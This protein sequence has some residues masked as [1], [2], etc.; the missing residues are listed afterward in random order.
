MKAESWIEHNLAP[1]RTQHR[2]RQDR[3]WPQAGARLERDGRTLINFAGNDYLGLAGDP[4]LARA[5][6]DAALAL[7]TGATASRLVCGTLDLHRD[8]E[9][10][11]AVFKGYPAALLFGSGYLACAGVLQAAADRGCVI[12]LDRLAHAS[13]LDGAALSRARVVRFHHNDPDHA[14]HLLQRTAGA[15]ALLVTESVFSMDGDLAPLPELAA[16][17]EAHD[18]LFVVDEAHATGVFGPHGAGLVSAHGLQPRVHAAITTFSKALGGYGGAVTCSAALRTWLVNASRPFIYTTAPPP[19]VLAAAR[20]ALELLAAEPDLGPALLARART[21]R[22]ALRADGFDPF[23]SDSPI[24][25]VRIGNEAPALAVAQRLEAAGFLVV[26]IR[27]PT[28]PDGTARL[29]ISISR[30]H[31]DADLQALRAALG[32]AMRAEGLR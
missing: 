6:A 28:V 7:G 29:R 24:V 21:F 18:A 2:E 23:Q 5:A 26:A 10:R 13:L 12:V 30:A 14:R 11:L 20:A 9:A 15:R 31:S 16:V 8:L 32:D 27:P 17:A 22:D 1:R 3:A 25:P 19:P 4:R